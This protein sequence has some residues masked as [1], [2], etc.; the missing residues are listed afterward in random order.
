VVVG[1]ILHHQHKKVI[2]L[3]KSVSPRRPAG[4]R[5]LTCT[6]PTTATRMRCQ[7]RLPYLKTYSRPKA[8]P[9]TL[10]KPATQPKRRNSSHP[11]HPDLPLRG[12]WSARRGSDRLPQVAASKHVQE[13]HK[14]DKTEDP[15][16]QLPA[17]PQV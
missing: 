3:R 5:P 16:C 17:R 14:W 13:G 6:P 12:R 11:K 10:T 8:R 4:E 15:P 1:V 2:D 7:I 9:R